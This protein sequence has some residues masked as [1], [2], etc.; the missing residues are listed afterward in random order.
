MKIKD[1]LEPEKK[2][3]IIE[4]VEYELVDLDLLTEAMAPLALPNKCEV[5]PDS[6]TL[7][8]KTFEEKNTRKYFFSEK[9]PCEKKFLKANCGLGT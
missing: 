4:G 2:I 5:Q 1:F 9:Y 6:L 3:Y 7:V 8:W